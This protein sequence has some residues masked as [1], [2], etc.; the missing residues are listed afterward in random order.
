MKKQP[1]ECSSLQDI[2]DEID[3]I[4]HEITIALGKRLDYVKA[5]S[6]FKPNAESIPAPERVAAM[7]PQRRFWAEQAGLEP[8]FIE[9]IFS[10][11]IQ[12]FINEQVRF[13]RSKQQS[14][15][16]HEKSN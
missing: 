12:W 1:S 16:P 5:A 11:L 13:Y 3:A 7:L 8:D 14:G 2:R 6:A 10:Q 9:H 15:E 4:D